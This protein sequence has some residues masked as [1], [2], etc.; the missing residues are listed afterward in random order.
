M[1]N[2]TAAASALVRSAIYRDVSRDA[3]GPPDNGR[4]ARPRSRGTGVAGK[5]A[6]R[7]L[8]ASAQATALALLGLLD[9]LG[10]G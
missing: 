8:R 9:M 7:R 3:V 5:A 10:R 4:G 2:G 6:E 1:R